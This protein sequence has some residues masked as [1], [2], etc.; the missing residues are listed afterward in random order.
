MELPSNVHDEFMLILK[1]ASE[2]KPSASFAA[3][4][5][6]VYLR[7]E[8]MQGVDE[9]KTYWLYFGDEN[10]K[11]CMLSKLPNLW[12]H[13][14]KNS[15]LRLGVAFNNC[16][17]FHRL[18]QLLLHSSELKIKLSEQT[19]WVS[20]VKTREKRISPCA[21]AYFV[22]YETIPDIYVDSARKTGIIINLLE[23]AHDKAQAR[24]N[25]PK[26]DKNFIHKGSGS[27][28]SLMETKIPFDE[29]SFKESFSFAY[30]VLRICLDYQLRLF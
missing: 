30:D 11:K 20:V 4:R 7:D 13:Q 8:I 1:W 29:K 5:N 15:F 14:P 22:P 12:V 6:E 25:L 17:S 28:A 21:C 3:K 19:N 18:H 2:A 24:T 16:N 10:S 27:A 23:E 26:S 9:D